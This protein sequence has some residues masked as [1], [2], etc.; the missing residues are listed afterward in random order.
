MLDLQK[1]VSRRELLGT[2]AATPLVLSAPLAAHGQ[3][4]EL[5]GRRRRRRPRGPAALDPAAGAW[6]TWLVP[7]VNGLLPSPP[8]GNNSASTRT[9]IRE[10]LQLQSQRTDAIREI[11]EFWDEQGGVPAWSQILLDKIRETNTNPV[12]AARAL[13]LFH[14]ALADATIA[15]WN[16]KFR[17]RR[18]QPSRLNRRLDCI[19]EIDHRLPAYPSE[20]AAVAAAALA[21]LSYLYPAQTAPVNGRRL[22]FPAAA[23]EAAASRLWAGANYRSDLGP[24]WLIGQAVGKLAVARGQVDG[25]ASVWNGTGRPDGPQYWVPTPPGNIANPL[26]PLA[27]NWTPWLLQSGD[28]F[29]SPVPPGLQGTFPSD[30]FLQETQEVYD[31]STN[32]TPEQ[33]QIANFWADGPGTFTPPGHWTQFTLMHL[34]ETEFSAPRAARVLALQ[35]VGVADSAIACWESKFFY[36]LM[37]P[38]TAIR[39]MAGQPFHNPDYLSPVG[40]PP[41]PAYTSGHSTFSGCSAKLL[42]QLFP[43]GRVPDAFDQN[44]SFEEAAEQAA[45]SR[46]YGGI[47]YR[48]DSDE[49]IVCGRAIADLV[50][51]RAAE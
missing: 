12:L 18:L 42:E 45:I 51:Q 11:V 8:P 27:G 15:V 43:G 7:S 3:G 26:L 49:G 20:H 33:L 41:F 2:L 44:I 47:H 40:T 34:A 29:R 4:V 22:T 25:S 10:L 14:T 38:I 6:R 17:Y 30:L 39:T 31:I 36:W 35:G 16:A 32:L 23:N 46:V 1:L 19:S 5:M 50:I 48:S 21:V 37:R 13:A 24:G 9:D 28:Q